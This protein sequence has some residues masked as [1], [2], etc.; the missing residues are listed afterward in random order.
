MYVDRI[1]A[2]GDRSR[3]RNAEV[4]QAVA[5]AIGLHEELAPEISSALRTQENDVNG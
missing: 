3:L 2:R 1:I 5:A 4:R